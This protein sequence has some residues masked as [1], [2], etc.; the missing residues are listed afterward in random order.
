MGYSSSRAHNNNTSRSS[1]CFLSSTKI[2][3]WLQA[4]HLSLVFFIAPTVS[5][6]PSRRA[7]G[8]KVG[9]ASWRAHKKR[10][11]SLGFGFSS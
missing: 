8:L 2:E 10:G 6:K 5:S 4:L 1:F 9:Y 7:F 11:Q 3:T